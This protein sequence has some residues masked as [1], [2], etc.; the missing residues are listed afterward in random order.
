M[1]KITTKFKQTIEEKKKG[2]YNLII[3]EEVHVRIVLNGSSQKSGFYI[4]NTCKKTMLTGEIFSMAVLNGLQLVK[5]EKYCQLTEL[6]NNLIAQ[7]S[8]FQYIFSLKKSKWAATKN[9]IISVPVAPEVVL[10]TFEQLPKTPREEGV[11]PMN[12]K[13]RLEFKGYHREEYVDPY[14]LFRALKYLKDCGHPYYQDIYD[15][16]P[17]YKKRCKE[18][19]I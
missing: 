4:C 8:N 7:N 5:M 15:E 9:R 2:L 19:G 16:L 3:P 17:T 6:E 1:T 10:Q 12:L 14:K 13:R 11:V 18:Q